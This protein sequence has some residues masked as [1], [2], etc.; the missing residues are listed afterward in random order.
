[1]VRVPPVGEWFGAPWATVGW[2]AATTTAMY[3]TVVASVRLA[4]RRT[5]ARLSAFDIVVTVALGSIVATTAVQQSASYVQ[6]A[7][8]VATLLVLQTLVAALRQ[9]FEVVRRFLDFR[10]EIVLRDGT[11]DLSASPL[12][13]QLTE[14]ELRSRL[15]QAGVF[16]SEGLR[17]VIVEPTGEISYSAHALDDETVEDL[18]R[19]R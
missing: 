11:F 8:A 9:K 10:P 2:V 12:G 3:A 16:E 18:S 6:G 1:M 14:T 4:G 15:R 7:T 19:H 5:L 17:I 13:P